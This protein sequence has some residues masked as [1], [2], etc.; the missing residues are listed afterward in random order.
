M[1]VCGD[2]SARGR[3]CGGERFRGRESLGAGRWGE[4]F[5]RP[6]RMEQERVAADRLFHSHRPHIAPLYRPT[7]IERPIHVVPTIQTRVYPELFPCSQPL[8][9]EPAP[10]YVSP[11]GSHF[12][13][14]PYYIDSCTYRER[15]WAYVTFVDYNLYQ[16]IECVPFLGSLLAAV[17]VA[18]G[19]FQL[20]VALFTLDA[21]LAVNGLSNIARGSIGFI[22]FAG[23]GVLA[24]YDRV[25]M[26]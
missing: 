21:T 6:C 17:R 3:F 13:R 9:L 8:E 15:S 25:I 20:F 26:A 24:L 7:R 10:L 12:A 4:G 2:I 19:T 11:A 16:G 22:P 14:Q 1:A 23:G 5:S 18:V